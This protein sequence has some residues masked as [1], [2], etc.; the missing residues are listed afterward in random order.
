M[1]FSSGAEV[2]NLPESLHEIAKLEPDELVYWFKRVFQ[3]DLLMQCTEHHSVAEID[4]ARAGRP[5]SGS[6]LYKAANPNEPNNHLRAS[7]L[8]IIFF[9]GGRHVLEWFNR[10]CGRLSYEIPEVE[11]DGEMGLCRLLSSVA[12]AFGDVGRALRAA[13]DPDGPSGAR[14]NRD[15]L[16]AIR[17]E[18]L[19]TCAALLGLVAACQ[20]YRG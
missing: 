15:E 1:I 7:D 8:P 4:E 2:K 5:T 12:A 6:F 9:S 11:A 20:E 10:L 18:A 3:L 19:E 14:I 16:E 13:V 17:K